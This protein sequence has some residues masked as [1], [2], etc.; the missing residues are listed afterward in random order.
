M[1]YTIKQVDDFL[2]TIDKTQLVRE[3]KRYVYNL[4]CSFDIETSSFYQAGNVV[5][6]NAEY[7]KA[8]PKNAI[9]KAIMYIWQF[10]IDDNVII[11][12]IV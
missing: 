1:L 9:K 7:R 2:S 10:A 4:A 6:T 12:Q 5:Y 3:Q 11:A 8:L